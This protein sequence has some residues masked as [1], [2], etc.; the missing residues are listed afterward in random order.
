MRIETLTWEKVTIYFGK[1]TESVPA[2]ARSSLP[3]EGSTDVFERACVY[4]NQK[5]NC[6]TV[7]DNQ[8]ATD[9]E[10]VHKSYLLGQAEIIDM[11]P[12]MMKWTAFFFT[13]D[14]ILV[15]VTVVCDF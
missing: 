10:A 9:R 15:P 8:R 11:T 14:R 7:K 5:I 2:T 4:Y 1:P 13:S 3:A 6:L 12:W